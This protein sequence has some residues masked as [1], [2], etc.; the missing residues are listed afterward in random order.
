MK[1]EKALDDLIEH[2]SYLDDL[3]TNMDY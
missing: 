1:S 2:Y 3:H